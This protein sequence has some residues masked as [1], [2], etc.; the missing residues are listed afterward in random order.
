MTG[1][2]PSTS[3]NHLVDQGC[4]IVVKG[5]TK[6]PNRNPYQVTFSNFYWNKNQIVNLVKM[7]KWG[8]MI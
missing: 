2:E 3:H 5:I 7:A 6:I 4:G 8:R 1:F